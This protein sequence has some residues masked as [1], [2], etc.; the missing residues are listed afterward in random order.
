M[1]SR[2]RPAVAAVTGAV[3]AWPF[4]ILAFAVVVTQFTMLSIPA[5]LMSAGLATAASGFLAALVGVAV[6]GR[7]YP[8]ADVDLRKVALA[9]WAGAAAYLLA[10]AVLVLLRGGLQLGGVT[11]GAALVGA[12]LGAAGGHL[13]L[14]RRDTRTA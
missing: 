8:S 3:A 6:A 12:G 1:G 7:G 14:R 13:I 4:S 2:S 9:A 5:I 10:G 11:A